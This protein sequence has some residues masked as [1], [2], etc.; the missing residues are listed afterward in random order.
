MRILDKLRRGLAAAAGGAACAALFVMMVVAVVDVVLR[1]L[2]NRP[3][4]AA[5]ELIEIAMVATI[6]LV[7]P[8]V[9][10]KGMH[11]SIDLLDDLMP[12]L[13]RRVQHVL[14]ALLGAAVFAAVAWRIG[15]L[16]REAW[17]SSEATGVLG[18]PLG[19][20]YAFICAL[21]TVTSLTF[22]CL[23]PRAWARGPFRHASQPLE[24]L[25]E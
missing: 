11:I 19:H 22:L 25:P 24:E 4:A 17:S 20:V 7:Y 5:S 2:F 1:T 16:A 13:L 21:S 10:W 3:L 6:F 12:D 23:V 15:F 8:L 14:A 18:I 9:S